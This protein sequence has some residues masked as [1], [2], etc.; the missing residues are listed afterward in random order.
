MV[1]VVVMA[2]I[3]MLLHHLHDISKDILDMLESGEKLKECQ[4]GT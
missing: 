3:I 1:Q 2:Y 4:G